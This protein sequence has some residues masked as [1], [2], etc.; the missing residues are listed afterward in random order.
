MDILF[1]VVGGFVVE[2]GKFISKCVYPKIE[3]FIRFSSKIENLRKEMEK[4]AK[5]RDAIKDKVE[6]AE[7]EGY[8]PKSDVIEW[9]EDVREL[10]KQWESMQDTIATAKTLVYKCCPKCRLRS[11]V[12]TQGQNIRDQ[13]CWLIEVGENFGSNLVVENYQMKNV[14]F[15]PGPSIEGQPAATRNLNGI[16]RL[17]ED[18]RVCIISVWGPGGVGKTTLVKNLNND[19]LKNVPSSKLSFGIV[20][21]VTV[22]KPPI[23]I[24]K[25]QAQIASRLNLKVDNE[26]SDKSISSKIFQRLKEEKSFLLILDDVWETINLDDVGV[27]QPEEPTRSK[28]IITSRFLDVC[29]QMRTNTEMKVA[30][31]KE[32]ESW[33]LF[34]KNTGDSAKLEHIQPLAQ[35]IARECDGL[36]LAITVVGTSMRGKT[37]VKLWED[38]LD[39]LRRSEPYNKNVKDK[40]YNV[41]KWSYDSLESLDIQRC[42]LYCS[43]CP[44]VVPIDDVI[45]CW[46]AEGILGEHDTYQK[47]YN[48]GIKIVETLTDDCML[49][50]HMVNFSWTRYVD[51]VNMHDVVRDVAIW[52]DN[53][54]GNE[55]NSLIQS[56]IGLTEISHVKVSVSVKR[57]SFIGNKIEHLPDCFTK[58]SVTASLLLQDNKLLEEIPRE[59]FLNY[60][61]LTVLNLSE[62]GIRA[63]PSSIN[64]LCQLRALILQNCPKLIELPPI[65][66]LHNLQLLDCDNTRLSC[67]PQGMDK[68]TNLRLLN[69][70]A[71][72]LKSINKGFFLTLSSIEKLNMLETEHYNTYYYVDIFSSTSRNFKGTLLGPTS[73]DEISY[74][75]NLT[76]LFI[77]LESSSIINRDHTW[78]ARL[79]RFHIEVGNFPYLI[80]FKKS[81]KAI[82][83][84]NCENFNGELSG[85]LQFASDLHLGNCTGFRK[86]IANKSFN[87]L[88]SLD[89][90]QCFRDFEQVE[91]GCGIDPLPNLEYL[92]L[93]MHY[94]LKSVSE[95]SQHLGLKFSKLRQLDVFNCYSLTHLFYVGGANWN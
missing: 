53:C 9:I 1:N 60:P 89:I 41:I 61:A 82:C 8:K 85:M 45:H 29:K 15:I 51:C 68:L 21:W 76:S 55:Q 37:R 88:K 95:F 18:D 42:F 20:I 86:L 7:G 39:S 79:K 40:V 74:L 63:L 2:V 6:G 91:E 71:Y 69:L 70:P 65:G 35:E 92:K 11:E 50:V 24:R 46:C 62:T 47:A 26:G 17:L 22:P 10:E 90:C 93:E 66:D 43:L 52:I 57:I 94:N 33:Q 72:D 59:F 19:L 73:F 77:T 30:T 14:E 38:A 84:S 48:R 23:D 54:F 13:L 25:I 78:M 56:G 31:L 58:C 16:L 28:V 75:H 64:S 83:I 80:H 32:D 44:V 36:P 12:S 87:G 27:P 3:S 81:A 49:E 5:F 34:V 4:L 67:P